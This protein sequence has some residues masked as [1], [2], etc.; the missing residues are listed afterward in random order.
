MASNDVE[1]KKEETTTIAKVAPSHARKPRVAR[2]ARQYKPFKFSGEAARFFRQNTVKP[3]SKVVT[4]SSINSRST[5]VRGDLLSCIASSIQQ[6]KH[7]QDQ[8][9]EFHASLSHSYPLGL[10][11]IE[12]VPMVRISSQSTSG[13]SSKQSATFVDLSTFAQG[14]SQIAAPDSSDDAAVSS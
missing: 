3:H 6:W 9:T 8:M 7:I 10:Q 12:Y 4:V 5:T 11:K 1:V 2:E 13:D 14:C